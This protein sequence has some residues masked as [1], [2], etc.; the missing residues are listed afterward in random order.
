MEEFLNNMRQNPAMFYFLIIFLLLWG[1]GILWG[2]ILVIKSLGKKSISFKYL[3]SKG[4][5]EV[6]NN[7]GLLERVKDIVMK[8]FCRDFALR[9]D[10]NP[11]EEFLSINSERGTVSIVY[12]LPEEEYRKLRRAVGVRETIQIVKRKLTLSRI[13]LRYTGHEAFYAQTTDTET[14]RAYKPQRQVKSITG[15]VLCFPRKN[16]KFET[17]VTI[18]RKFT[19]YRKF[20]MDMAYQVAQIKPAQRQGILPEFSEE[21]EILS[22]MTQDSS[23]LLDERLQ[24]IILEHK[25]YIPEGVKLFINEEGVWTTGEEAVTKEQ[26]KS[27]VALCEELVDALPST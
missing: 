25:K 7:A 8:T 23:P 22:Q 11:R 19:G 20:L 10:P 26:M 17:T 6:K 5:V 18:Y 4:F 27:I 21:F 14:I 15:W 1:G 16:R 3:K 2:I 13:L 24:R 9:V 12:T